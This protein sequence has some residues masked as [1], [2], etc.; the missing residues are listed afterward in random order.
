MSLY[1]FSEDIYLF[2]LFIFK[3]SKSHLNPNSLSIQIN[4]GFV[5]YEYMLMKDIL[6]NNREIK[7]VRVL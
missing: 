3:D 6:T 2:I 1:Y 4:Y 5:N 7:Y